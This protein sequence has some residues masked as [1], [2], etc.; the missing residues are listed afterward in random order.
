MK[1]IENIALI[2]AIIFVLF[3]ALRAWNW[4]GRCPN[5]KSINTYCDAKTSRDESA[6]LI[7][8]WREDWCACSKCK[9]TWG[10][11][12]NQIPPPDLYENSA[13]FTNRKQ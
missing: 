7:K 9:H 4:A 8:Y 10:H 12:N 3:A 13:T 1:T 5:C 11:D 6:G 2:V